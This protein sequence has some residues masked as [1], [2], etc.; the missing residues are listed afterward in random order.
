M[1]GSPARP[2]RYTIRRLPDRARTSAVG[3]PLEIELRAA[4]RIREPDS[5]TQNAAANADGNPRHAAGRRSR[6]NPRKIAESCRNHLTLLTALMAALHGPF[7]R[8]RLSGEHLTPAGSTARCYAPSE[9]SPTPVRDLTD[10][11]SFNPLVYLRHD[12]RDQISLRRTPLHRLHAPR[13][14]AAGADQDARPPRAGAAA[15]RPRPPA[16]DRGP[17]PV[18]A[19]RLLQRVRL[20]RARAALHGSCRVAAY[21]GDASVPRDPRR[22]RAAAGR[23]AEPEQRGPVAELLRTLG[24]Q[25]RRSARR[26]RRQPD[27]AP[28]DRGQPAPAPR[29][30]PVRLPRRRRARRRVR[31]CRCWMRTPGSNWWSVR[32]ARAPGRCNRCWPRWIPRRRRPPSGCGRW[33]TGAGS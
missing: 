32:W 15:Q 29:R 11:G 27:R 4:S 10:H 25:R 14:G 8:L 5:P 31:P 22:P 3:D 19:P 13:P 12:Q 20:H 23:L 1:A 2:Y 30:A 24:A 6:R 17:A 7:R 28:P 9:A 26:I 21:Q 18:P 33:G 16:R